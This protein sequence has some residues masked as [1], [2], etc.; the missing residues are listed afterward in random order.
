V[1]AAD[2]T[3]CLIAASASARVAL[4]GRSRP[5]PGSFAAFVQRGRNVE[6]RVAPRLY[7]ISRRGGVE[8]PEGGFPAG[9]AA[10]MAL[11]GLAD[12]AANG[13]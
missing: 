4:I 12:V 1:Q 6:H 3:A 8:L 5:S 13:T 10:A 7:V 11:V 2:D 9:F